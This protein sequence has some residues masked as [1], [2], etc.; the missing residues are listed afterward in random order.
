MTKLTIEAIRCLPKRL[1]RDGT[2][3]SEMQMTGCAAFVVALHPRFAPMIYN[4][5]GKWKTMKFVKA[6]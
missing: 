1:V 2:Q 4:G 5:T 3:V 6:P